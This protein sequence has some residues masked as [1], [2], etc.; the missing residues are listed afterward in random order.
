ML[1]VATEIGLIDQLRAINAEKIRSSFKG[2][3]NI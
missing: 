2:M 3:Q 1:H